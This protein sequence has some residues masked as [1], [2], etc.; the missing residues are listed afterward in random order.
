MKPVTTEYLL[1]L[2]PKTE[3]DL[4]HLEIAINQL[5]G[6]Q[7][8]DYPVGSAVPAKSGTLTVKR[9]EPIGPASG[10]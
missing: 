1:S 4:N 8:R 5:S 7:I 3:I 9:S 2:E 6:K 10:K